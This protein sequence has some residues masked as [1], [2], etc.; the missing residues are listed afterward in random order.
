[1]KKITVT[2]LLSDDELKRLERIAEEYKKQQEMNTTPER[3]FEGIMTCGAKY[4]IDKKFKIHEEILRLQNELK[5][6]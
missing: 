2:Y 1:M 5:S 4:D 6:L 3:M